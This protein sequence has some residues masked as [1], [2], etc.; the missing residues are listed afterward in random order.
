MI[1]IPTISQLYNDILADLQTEFNA[2][3]SPFGKSFLRAQAAVQ[4]AKLKLFYLAIGDLQ[5]NIFVDTADPASQGGT[6]ERFG[7]IKLGR[8]PFT[9]TQAQ[10]NCTVTGAMGA[11]IPA[12][13]LFKSDDSSLNPGYLFILD[14]AY[15]M[16][17]G[18]GTIIL[19]ALT[20]GTISSLN[21]SDTLTATA[22]IIN[23]NS[24][25]VVGSVAVSPID[26]ETT[27]QYRAKAL[28]A[29]R[30]NPEGGSSAD[31][32][33]WGSDAAGVQQI[34]PYTA[35]GLPNEINVFVEAILA[36]STD[37]KG[38]PTSTI[39]TAV[40]NDIATD[41]ITG[42][43]RKPLGVLAVNV[44]AIIINNVDITINSGGT[45]TTAQQA[46]ITAALTQAISTIRPF[47]PGADA[48][49][50]KNDIL[51]T[52]NIINVILNTIPGLIF[53]SVTLDI[54]STPETS[55]VFDLGNI[56]YLHSVSY[57]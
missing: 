37:G 28:Q 57:V 24:G 21:I 1:N 11:V 45:I 29:Y 53:S 4:A 18:T 42:K 52:N 55:Y 8:N 20:G 2:T 15:T 32:R 54:N 13:T 50:A 33:L 49:T 35:S 3:V 47:I 22:P 16:P 39:L 30:L 14:T 9:A 12:Q 48:I 23:V 56:P 51:S 26:A 5:K 27:E 25:A 7:L 44:A 40:S 41:P 36:D 46:L 19:R 10:Y 43:G 31:Y 38:T 17:S 34:Y 6:L